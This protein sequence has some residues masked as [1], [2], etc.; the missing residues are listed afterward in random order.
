MS[1]DR[2]TSSLVQIRSP[3]RTLIISELVIASILIVS[4][5][6]WYK[7]YRQ[8]P[9]VQEKQLKVAQLNV[10][11][12]AVQSC[13]Y[14]ELLTGFG[15]AAAEREVVLAAQVTGEIVDINPELK[16]GYRVSGGEFRSDGLPT[17]ITDGDLLLTID[18]REYQQ[19][20]DQATNGIRE[21]RTEIE[22]LKVQ[23]TSVE[24]QL[25]KG[26]ELLKTLKEEYNRYAEAVQ[27]NAGSMSDRNRSLLEVQRYEDILIQ[28]ENQAAMLP[29]QIT[30]AEH[31]LAT[32]EPNFSELKTIWLERVC[33]L[34][35][36]EY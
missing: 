8:K 17:E 16:V 15:T 14:R 18:P 19:R 24:R 36:V 2:P 33:V 31:R 20:V 26:R 12:F 34:R 6:T 29:H 7:L 22:R 21:A 4:A 25:N 11:V 35:S 9:T 23:Q 28:L 3:V 30:V 27:R 32:G 1:S 5:V 13:Q 10:D